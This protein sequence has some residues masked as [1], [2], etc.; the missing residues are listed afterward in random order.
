MDLKF[1]AEAT[2][3]KTKVK[4]VAYSGGL[5]ADSRGPVVVDLKGMEIPA[6]FPL[7]SGHENDLT[8][9][10]G[11][12]TAEVSKGQ[13]LVTGELVA[14]TEGKHVEALLRDGIK[15]QASIGAEI[16]ASKGIAPG[17]EI[18]VNGQILSHTA[19]L[20]L[21]SKSR[22]REVSIVALGADPATSIN[23]AAK[24]GTILMTT[25]D[26]DLN[27]TREKVA[28]EEQRID[29]I[30][31]AYD[32]FSRDGVELNAEYAKT[33]GIQ[34]AD[35][36]TLKAHAIREGWSVDKFEL[37]ARRAERPNMGKFSIHA[38]A[39][40][41]DESTLEA[42]LGMHLGF[43]VEKSY[44][45]RTLECA[46]AL[47]VRSF[48]DALRLSLQAQG[49]FRSSDSPHEMLRASS[50]T[51]TASY[52]Y[53]LGNI[54][55]KEL[56][57]AYKGVDSIARKVS[58]ILSANDFKTNY[59][60]QIKDFDAKP[61][62]LG[63]NG[64][65]KHSVL[66]ERSTTFAVD[67]YARLVAFD[68]KDLINDDLSAFSQLPTMLARGAAA[69]LE[70]VFWT[71]VLANAGGTFFAAGNNNYIS[72]ATTTL[73]QTGL[74]LGVKNLMEQKDSVGDPIGVRPKFLI[75]PPAL[76]AD[77]L[78][79]YNSAEILLGSST[80]GDRGSV[81]PWK[82]TAEPLCTP[83]LGSNAGLSGASDTAWYLISEPAQLACFGIAYLGGNSVPMV[84]HIELDANR[85]GEG[86]RC[87][88]DFGTALL[89]A[90]AG[91]K[92]KGAA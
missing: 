13:L 76:L 9:I 91:C 14:T 62:T 28:T 4:V 23:I 41:V 80:T 18:K 84:E 71:M 42:A 31:A 8:A 37:E 25:N 63:V 89:E 20:L 75:V 29:G 78:V 17:E 2:T 24:Q 81:N 30:R 61:E 68:R 16:L 5:I 7:L 67:Q 72:G 36:T 48:M 32:S 64:E 50:G 60:V 77:A 88:F 70:K 65:I 1:K 79:L 86:W 6:N 52:T 39:P 43:H 46:K 19:G 11:Q 54:A 85:L 34:N 82:G 26:N 3:N 92:S 15:L 35:L 90:K 87:V 53:L 66:G 49:R 74:G 55:N 22:L 44:D 21:V 51:S 69:Q 10:V 45:A 40:R 83:W 33:L 59:L 27:M 56:A 73:T 12:G 57:D 47:G 38:T 58:R